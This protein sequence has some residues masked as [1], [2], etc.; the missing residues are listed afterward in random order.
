VNTEGS[1][2]EREAY[3]VMAVLSL[4]WGYNWVVIRIATTD[5]SPIF[6]ATLRTAIGA[7]TLLLVIAARRQLRP[8]PFV[9]TLVLGLLQTFAFTIL[10]TIA[11]ALGGAGKVAVL[12]YTMPFWATLFAWPFLGER[13]VG[14]RWLA[15]ALAAVG[16]GFVAAPFNASTMWGDILAVLAGLAWGASVVWARRLQV[17]DKLELLP[18]TAWQTVWAFI[19]MLVIALIVPEH[20]HWT[21]GFVAAMLFLG[22]AQGVAWTMWLF[23]L[24]RLPAGVAG[25]ASL[26][27][28]V[29]GVAFAALQLHEI[30]SHSELFGMAL[31]IGA[32]A[33]NTVPG[34][35]G[36]MRQ[37][38]ATG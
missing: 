38:R 3:L 31:I 24:G 5:G 34:L 32:L 20:V 19:P 2:R 1:A 14:I 30:P 25:I 29:L 36:A 8:T 33:L 10:Q 21:D 6:V 13:I 4:I 12:A 16:L 23:V 28:P 17:R 26:A 18:L 9:P 22:V 15:L 37:P 11:V 35:A 27:T 7:F